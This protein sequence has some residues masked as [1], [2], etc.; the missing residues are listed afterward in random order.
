MAQPGLV[1]F[2][3][4]LARL[5]GLGDQIAAFSRA[6]DFELFRPEPKVARSPSD[7]SKGEEQE[8][9]PATRKGRTEKDVTVRP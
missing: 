6:I 7:S 3:E 5:S 2:D 1:D 9:F 8:L 4:R